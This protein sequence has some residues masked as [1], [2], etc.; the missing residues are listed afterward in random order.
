M[1]HVYIVEILHYLQLLAA[2]HIDALFLIL[3]LLH[4]GTVQGVYCIMFLGT[5]VLQKYCHK[6][7]L[8]PPE[9]QPTLFYGKVFKC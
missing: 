7:S 5:M 2:V 3:S 8:Y 9:I 1:Q 4:M 6:S